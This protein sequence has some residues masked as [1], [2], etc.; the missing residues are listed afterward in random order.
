MLRLPVRRRRDLASGAE[1]RVRDAFAIL[2]DVAGI[3]LPHRR[4]EAAALGARRVLGVIEPRGGPAELRV[5]VVA[6]IEVRTI[7]RAP[8]GAEHQTALGRAW[9]LIVVAADE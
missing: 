6:Q 2:D 4:H 3:H 8:R 9:P 1:E 5:A 7:R